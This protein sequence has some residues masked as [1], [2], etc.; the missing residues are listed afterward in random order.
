MAEGLGEGE[1]LTDGH[2]S[3]SDPSDQSEAHLLCRT[4]PQAQ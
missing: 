4:T 3:V 1:V 2:C